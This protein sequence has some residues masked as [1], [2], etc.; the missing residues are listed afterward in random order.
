MYVCATT[1]TIQ[2]ISILKTTNIISVKME[3][4]R[5]VIYI[6]I[7]NWLPRKQNNQNE[8]AL[9][10]IFDTNFSA[11]EWAFFHFL[12]HALFFP[13][14]WWNMITKC[15]SSPSLSPVKGEGVSTWV[16]VSTV[17]SQVLWAMFFRPPKVSCIATH[18]SQ[19]EGTNCYTPG[20]AMYNRAKWMCGCQV[21]TGEQLLYVYDMR[22]MLYCLANVWCITLA[23]VKVHH[24]SDCKGES[25]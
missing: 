10:R 15:D 14:S 2:I 22:C 25:P 1:H 13:P 16:S 21:A 6:I 7:T 17:I 20:G 24:P 12:C 3:K 5:Y 9:Y 19:W 18:W 11:H 23:I 4:K 8:L